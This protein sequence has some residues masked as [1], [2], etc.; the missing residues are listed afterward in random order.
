MEGIGRALLLVGA[1]ILILGLAFMLAPKIPFLGKLPG[2][3]VYRRGDSSFYFPLA[4]S[5]IVSIAL[6]A[7]VNIALRLFR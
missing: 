3:I 5:I 6:T 1:A 2:D 7:L 4:T